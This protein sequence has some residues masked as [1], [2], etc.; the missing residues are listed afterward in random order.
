M[1][2]N[3]VVGKKNEPVIIAV[4][5]NMKFHIHSVCLMGYFMIVKVL[6]DI[7]YN[8]ICSNANI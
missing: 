1:K 4:Y 6:L 5:A 3:Q 7:A 2:R 8:R